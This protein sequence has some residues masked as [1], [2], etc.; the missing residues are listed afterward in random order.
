MSSR[1]LLL[2]LSLSPFGFVL[3]LTHSTHTHTNIS[4]HF[5]CSFSSVTLSKS[6]PFSFVPIPKCYNTK[7]RRQEKT[8]RWRWWRQ[9]NSSPTVLFFV[10]KFSLVK[11]TDNMMMHKIIIIWQTP[12]SRSE[13]QIIPPYSCRLFLDL[14]AGRIL[15]FLSIFPKIRKIPTFSTFIIQG[16]MYLFIISPIHYLHNS[17]ENFVQILRLS[18][19]LPVCL[20][21]KQCFFNLMLA[22][23]AL[24]HRESKIIWV[25]IS[26]QSH[27]S[28]GG[29]STHGTIIIFMTSPLWCCGHCCDYYWKGVSQL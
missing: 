10:G 26:P 5:S 1:A 8:G 28:A 27:F 14:L 29:N 17:G 9:Q 4:T 12:R 18:F 21:K 22:D 25:R 23:S 24:F 2:F 6:V 16:A 20:Q 19:C 15:K 3:S 11:S 7:N 13:I